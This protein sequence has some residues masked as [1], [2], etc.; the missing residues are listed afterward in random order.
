MRVSKN[1]TKYLTYLDWY[2]LV[3]ISGQHI[4][5]VPAIVSISSNIILH[6]EYFLDNILS[7][8][9][10]Q[11]YMRKTILSYIEIFLDD[12]T[13]P[14]YE[15]INHMMNQCI[16]E[17]STCNF[18]QYIMFQNILSYLYLSWNMSARKYLHSSFA[19]VG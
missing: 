6:P 13:Y 15:Y 18:W 2:Y 3:A 8:L 14:S 4:T 17:T 16:N 5:C 7:I 9:R 10:L 11:N 12:I 19:F 1:N